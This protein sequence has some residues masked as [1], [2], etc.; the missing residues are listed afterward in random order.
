MQTG[1]VVGDRGYICEAKAYELGCCSVYVLT[2][3]RKNMRKLTSPFQL[4]C[5]Q[6]RH[7]TEEFFAFINFTFGLVRSTHRASYVLPMHLLVCFLA[8]SLSK[9]V[10]V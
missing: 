10:I 4:A 9:Q 6:A 3:I 1:M 5:L 2:S 8:Y 7:R